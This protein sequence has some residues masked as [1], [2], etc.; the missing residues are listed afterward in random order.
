MP[1]LIEASSSAVGIKVPDL[2]FG[3]VL[4]LPAIG[5]AQADNA[6]FIFSQAENQHIKPL[7]DVSDRLKTSFWIAFSA[8]YADHR[9]FPFKIMCLLKPHL[10]LADIERELACIESIAQFLYIQNKA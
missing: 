2:S 4:H 3:I 5:F 1:A 6:N 8:V 10:M 7:A 9:S